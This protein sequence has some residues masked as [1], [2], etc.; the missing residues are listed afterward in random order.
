MAIRKVVPNRYKRSRFYLIKDDGYP[1]LTKEISIFDL[2]VGQKAR[3][4]N[5]PHIVKRIDENTYYLCEMTDFH[6][7]TPKNELVK[8]ESITFKEVIG[9]WKKGNKDIIR[10][11]IGT[12]V[13]EVPKKNGVDYIHIFDYRDPAL[14]KL[15]QKLS[16]RYAK[17]F[18]FQTFNQLFY[19]FVIELLDEL[20]EANFKGYENRQVIAYIETLIEAKIR[21][22][23]ENIDGKLVKD[24]N[25]Q[26]TYEYKIL[27]TQY[28]KGDNTYN[29]LDEFDKK[30]CENRSYTTTWISFIDFLKQIDFRNNSLTEQQRIVWD[31]LLIKF[32]NNEC[33]EKYDCKE[34]G[35]L[36][37]NGEVNY[38]AVD[39]KR[40]TYEDIQK[41]LGKKKSKEILDIE[42]QIQNKL[43]KLI[44]YYKTNIDKPYVPMSHRFN[45][46][47]NTLTDALE[48][49]DDEKQ[50]DKVAFKM[51]VNFL[52]RQNK[53][54][55]PVRETDTD[56][57]IK[58]D[59][60]FQRQ[61]YHDVYFFLNDNL[62]TLDYLDEKLHTR[63]AKL[64]NE[65]IVA[66][67]DELEKILK[68][69][70][71]TT[72][73]TFVKKCLQLMYKYLENQHRAA[74]E[75][76]KYVLTYSKNK[77]KK[78]RKIYINSNLEIPFY[79]YKK[80]KNNS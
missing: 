70:H 20:Q 39:C 7:Y 34:H 75:M 56:N 63:S 16:S 9:E 48:L 80:V 43:A 53:K 14:N 67:D 4:K 72:K 31:L 59:L 18:D 38:R 65:I 50:A 35:D 24:E 15:F 22:E 25:G 69:T 73:K 28:E 54:I 78:K 79:N 47:L 11:L 27:S 8:G 57:E 6:T 49:I 3:F 40:I 42:E 68:N 33:T 12:R 1:E 51:L 36:L 5:Q 58:I 60:K 52:R 45:D 17:K 77:G 37:V 2:E 74:E 19:V 46:F 32:K 29:L 30:N 44:T 41:A 21:K 64:L 23:L 76:N 13:E 26:Y 55:V 71:H 66:T 10:R 62:E 61:L